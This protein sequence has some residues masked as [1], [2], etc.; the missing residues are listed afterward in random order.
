MRKFK[1]YIQLD[2][3][4]CGPS[5]LR[6]VSKHYGKSFS[7][8]TL[9][10]ASGISR[11]GVSLLGISQAAE[12]IGFHTRGVQLSF[13]DL[14]EN[15]PLPCI[16]HWK[17]KHFVVVYKIKKGHVH[18]A[19]PTLGL[20]TYSKNEFCESWNSI[21][22]PS[23]ESTGIALLLEPTNAFY[24]EQGE[25]GGQ[26]G[27]KQLFAYLFSYKKLLAQLFVGL[28]AG[29]IIQLILPF[30]TQSIV[31]IGI[32]TQ[33]ISFIYIIL[34]AQIALFTGRTSIEFIRS[35][36]L[37]HISVRINISILTDFLI[38][39]MRLPLSF[40]DVKLFGDIMQ[41][42]S[43]QQRIETFL[44][45][46]SLDI[47]FSL[48]NLVIFGGVLMY[49]NN[50]IFMVFLF[51]SILYTVWVIL[52]LNTRRKLDF[53]RFELQSKEQSALVELINGMQEIKLA[54]AETQK[55]WRWEGFRSRLFKLN[56][57]SL[58]LNQIQ[59]TGAHFINEGKN[60]LTTFLAAKAV[61]SGDMTLG[62]ML[63]VQ[64]IIGQ[65]NSPVEQLVT[66]VQSFQQ[67]KISLERLSEIHEMENEE[68]QNHVPSNAKSREQDIT[69]NNLSFN[70]GTAG[71]TNVL[72]NVSIKIPAGKTTAIVGMS[73]SGKTTLL[74][75][76]LKFYNPTSGNIQLGR[77]NLK[78]VSHYFWR[79]SCGV[80]GQDGFIFSDTISSN[81]AVGQDVIDPDRLRH[82]VKMANIE[83]FID[84][85][86]LGYNTKIGAEGNGISQGQKQRIL[87]ARAVYKDPDY[88]FFDE[89]TNALDA[90]NEITIMNNLEK[91]FQGRTVVVVAHR[92]STVKNADQII[93]L[94]NGHVVEQGN[95]FELVRQK[96]KYYELV[97][98]QLELGA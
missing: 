32:N 52:F 98:N 65:L 93:V 63:S 25:V 64:Y 94:Q 27:F 1:V 26:Y 31:D 11:E 80:V 37:L 47:V 14:A 89:A 92:L 67:A 3:M 50:T 17:Q 33:N 61:I 29:S 95:H 5:C 60:I 75:L 84:S 82:A 90:N 40:F 7:L 71:G 15:S 18:V 81:I 69:V 57:K 76:L 13:D 4:D 56:T 39:L 74:K 38:K 36:I 86:P 19:D 20:V 8:Q 10:L 24:E 23:G 12:K 83:S 41:R 43:D 49:F 35:W 16:V 28:V 54:N 78:D 46:S 45:G 62:T 66:F 72:E 48:F 6:M 55:R 77:S 73:G 68:S 87:I 70:Y 53:K 79:E 58:S 97:K 9:R 30:L 85:L 34:A 21:L 88:I 96:G 44:T 22:S 51:S 91:F 42:M 59:Q 2:M